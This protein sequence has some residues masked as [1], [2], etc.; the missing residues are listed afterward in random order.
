MPSVATLAFLAIFA[1]DL[2]ARNLMIGSSTLSLLLDSKEGRFVLRSRG[3]PG[4]EVYLQLPGEISGA[5]TESVRHPLWGAGSA[6]RVVQRN[7]LTTT[8]ALYEGSPFLHMLPTVRN[9]TKGA[10]EKNDLTVVQ[11]G[12]RSRGSSLHSFGTEGLKETAQARGSYAFSVFA[13]A[14]TRH[15]M[16]AAFLTCER[17]IGVLLPSA[18]APTG[19]GLKGLD[20]YLCARLEFGRLRVEPG[21]RRPTDTLLLGLFEDARLGLESYA[22][23]VARLYG[24]KPKEKSGVYC[25]WYHV[26][27]SNEKALLENARFVSQNLKPFGLRVIQ[28]DDGWQAQIPEGMDIKGNIPRTG[29]VKVFVAAR[30]NYPHGMAWTAR[31]VS[32][33]GLVPG[34]WFMPFAGN[35][36]HPYFPPEIFAKNPDGSPF[37]D[38][39]WSGTCIDLSNPRAQDFVRKR[40]ERIYNWGYRYFKLDG[41]H[42]GMPTYNVYVNRSYRSDDGFNKGILYDPSFTHVE[43]FRTGLRIVRESAPDA[44]ILGC[45]IS[46]NLRSMAPSFGFVDA[47]R[48]G[49]DNGGAARG[50]WKAVTAGAFHGTILY[51]LNGRIWHN[52]PDP[53]YVRPST[54]MECARWMCSWVSVAGTMH[55][56]S[57]QY[58]QLPPERLELLKRSLPTHNLHARPVDLFETP[59]PRI[60]FVRDRRLAIIGLFNWQEK[61]RLDLKYDLERI[62]LQ[63]GR[64][65]VAFEYWSDRL[66][67]NLRKVLTWSLEPRGCAVFAVKPEEDHPQLLSTSRHITQGLVDV[68]DESWDAATATLS[69]KSKVVRGDRY[70]LRV[71]LPESPALD[72]AGAEAGGCRLSVERSEAGLLRLSFVPER[73]GVISWRIRFK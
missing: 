5:E 12:L 61:R 64:S 56:S 28:I 26:G 69:G 62:G 39:R 17:G 50:R 6:I 24:I 13:D 33:L 52:D 68:L 60:W 34:I 72:V 25:S 19:F 73:S 30:S 59:R 49:P 46:Q 27:A 10:L 15:G 66:V 40:V 42:T 71:V 65:Y 37:H 31:A 2:C 11:I 44:F 20:A 48:I 53:V 16:V 70:E 63:A 41:L 23:S 14:K 1:V 18:Q 4:W 55:T 21:K 57:Y 35:L 67:R 9:E 22:E 54:P 8:L 38:A 7:V 45:T 32:R 3:L 51:F 29:P 47:M 36:R 58:S 43:A